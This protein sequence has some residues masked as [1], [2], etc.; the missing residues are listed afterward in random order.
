[1]PY[2]NFYLAL[3]GTAGP[4][5]VETSGQP[6]KMHSEEA[7]V[8]VDLRMAWRVL[9]VFWWPWRALQLSL[10]GFQQPRCQHKLLGISFAC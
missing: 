3:A 4:S 10:V 2:G 6:E 8:L 7:L 5:I 9:A 1:M